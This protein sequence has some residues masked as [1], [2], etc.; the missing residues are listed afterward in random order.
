MDYLKKI[1]D[2]LSENMT[3]ECFKLWLDMKEKIYN[4]WEKPSSSTLKYHKKEDG[5]VQSIIE[6]TYEM[7]YATI[8]LLSIFNIKPKSNECNRLLLAVFCHDSFKYG[9]SSNAIFN[10]H[11]DKRHDKITADIIHKNRNYF[12][13]IFNEKEI[14]LLE[15]NVRYH[16]GRWSTDAKQ[17]F[18]FKNLD[19]TTMFVHMLDMM[20]SRNLIK[21]IDGDK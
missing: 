14:S 10:L 18:S 2:I 15:E 13:Q 16:S 11:T 1:E 6:H 9:S 4:I 12:L 17:D 7:I 3:E 8:P 5:S 19:P 20:S 21:I